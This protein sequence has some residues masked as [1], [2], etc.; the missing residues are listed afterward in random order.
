ML[1]VL[2]SFFFSFIILFIFYIYTILRSTSVRP[3]SLVRN[4]VPERDRNHFVGTGA[5]SDFWTDRPI[6]FRLNAMA[7]TRIQTTSSYI[8]QNS[9][10]SM[11]FSADWNSHE[12]P[13]ERAAVPRE[14]SV[15]RVCYAC[16]N[17]DS[18]VFLLQYTLIYIKNVYINKFVCV[19]ELN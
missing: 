16:F 8:P 4:W 18:S 14:F 11:F 6:T 5:N 7:D 2:I 19:I 13:G 3:S 1:Y 9:R 15:L 17:S 12:C 10:N